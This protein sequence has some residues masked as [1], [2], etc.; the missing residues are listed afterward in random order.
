MEDNQHTR[1]GNDFEYFGTLL[2]CWK[3]GAEHT[4]PLHEYGPVNIQYSVIEG[5]EAERAKQFE[6]HAADLHMI[7]DDQALKFSKTSTSITGP[8]T[9]HKATLFMPNGEVSY[10]VVWIEK[11]EQQVTPDV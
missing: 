8:H 6:K 7:A 4:M 2:R 1:A 3:S 11:A 9:H 5:T 10:T